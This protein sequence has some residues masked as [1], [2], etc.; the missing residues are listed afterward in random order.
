MTLVDEIITLATTHDNSVAT[1][2][3]KCLVLAYEL[4]NE[5]LKSWVE[6][7]L[8]GYDQGDEI[9]EYRNV[10]ITAKGHLRGPFG[11]SISNQPIP[12]AILKADHRHWAET[13]RLMQPVASYEGAGDNA[14][15]NWPTNLTLIYQ[16]KI[17][18]GYGLASAWQELPGSLLVGVVEIVRNKVLKF[19]LEIRQELKEVGDKPASVP[20]ERVE[21]AV[22]NYIF[23]GQNIIA[24]T[25]KDFTQVGSIE[26]A[27]GDID[28][29]SAALKTLDVKQNEIEALKRAIEADKKTFGVWTKEWLKN[30]GSK[31]GDAGIKIGVDVATGFVKSWLRKYF[32]G[33]DLDLRV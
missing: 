31:L 7:E 25:A 22:I 11:S 12:S 27:E 10:P 8:N 6:H 14:I 13:A 30:V 4:K 18:D 2:L 20:P 24:G 32:G 23:G 5:H 29:L 9:P 33:I 17:I 15:I 3:R 16:T 21:A 1:V 19:A 28:G 26:I